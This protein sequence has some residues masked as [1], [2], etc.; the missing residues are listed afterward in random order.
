MSRAAY[1]ILENGKVFEGKA[2]GAE[3]ETMGE[4]VFTTAMTGYLETLTDPCYFGQVVMQTFPLIGNYGVIPADFESDVPS[5]NAYIVREWCQ[6]PSNF[7][8]EGNL[9]TFLKKS[10]IPGIYGIDTRALT[11]IVR[12]NGTLNCK[13]S[14]S[15]EVSEKELEEIKNYTVAN[16]VESTTVK[17]KQSFEA[18]NAEYSV[19]LIDLGAR[20]G[21]ESELLKRGCSVTVVPA[22]ASA[23][24]IAGMN[25]D[26]IVLSDGPGD[27]VKNTKLIEELKKLCESKV[28]VFGIS[29]GHQV[30]ALAKGAKTEKL[31]YGH[32]G[33]SQPVKE[34]ET[35]RILITS[36]NHGYTV[37]NGSL[38]ECAAVSYENS[39]D[40]TC[41][42]I[43]YSDA[44]AFSVQFRPGADGG[45]LETA[46]L[47][48]R[49]VNMI[50]EYKNK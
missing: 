24:E 25:P 45:P 26:G 37:A 34:I 42:G 40:G 29:L 49:F 43:A 2:F 3:K 38:P 13:L 10:G 6:V 15:S 31:K 5:L 16:A 39:N 28:P 30:L 4:L 33:A 47:F 19:V 41:E 48:D 18:E 22:S 36:Q 9:D 11:K 17:A 14:Y 46:F 21:V 23:E 32:G 20:H 50:K 12:E 8:C 27:P 35:G 44:P 1:L 7:R